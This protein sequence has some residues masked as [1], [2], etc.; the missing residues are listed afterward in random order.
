MD[1][2]FKLLFDYPVVSL[3]LSSLGTL[4]VF[5]SAVVALTPSK[6]DDEALEGL[7]KKPLIKK[8]FDFLKKFSVIQKK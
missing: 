7:L 1:D 8:A 5:A 4:V 3:V 6:K 2:L